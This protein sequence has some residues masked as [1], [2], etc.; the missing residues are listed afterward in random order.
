M[1]DVMEQ[2]IKHRAR[3]LWEIAGSPDGRDEEFWHKA[4]QQVR[5]EAETKEKIDA[6]PNTSTNS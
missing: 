2:R 6:N 5:G 3:E 4:E 1:D